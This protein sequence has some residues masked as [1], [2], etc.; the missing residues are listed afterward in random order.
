VGLL[1]TENVTLEFTHDGVHELAAVAARVNAQDENIGARRLFTIVERVLEDVS[2]RAEDFAG[3]TV[4]I[5][6]AFVRGR[7]EGLVG[8]DDLRRYVL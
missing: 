6:A 8:N 7:L 5:D 2:F 4:R 3:H 1:G